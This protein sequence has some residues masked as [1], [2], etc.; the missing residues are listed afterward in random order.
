MVDSCG[1]R[2][3][4]LS[5][6]LVNIAAQAIHPHSFAD[7]LSPV[8]MEFILNELSNYNSLMNLAPK[9]S[10]SLAAR[11]QKTHAGYAMAIMAIVLTAAMPTW[12][13]MIRR[14]KEEELIFRGNQYARAISQY[15][16]KFANAS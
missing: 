2:S 13:Q 5:Q 12:S 4:S 9:S 10:A 3:G 11:S 16:R 6:A 1:A 7:C 15:Q 8:M 14:E